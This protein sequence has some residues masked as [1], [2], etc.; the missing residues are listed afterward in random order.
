[1]VVGSAFNTKY[2]NKQDTFATGQLIITNGSGLTF[3]DLSTPI[4]CNGWFRVRMNI[5]GLTNFPPIAELNQLENTGT[6]FA[7]NLLLN[8]NALPVSV[9]NQVLIDLDSITTG[10]TG[11][12]GTIN[13]SGQTPSAP[14]SGAGATAKT[15]LIGK[16]FTLITD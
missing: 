3:D 7:I 2:E 4:K 15:N 8:S 11:Y 5:S 6:A 12:S 14:P 13:L 16:G 10:Y 1:M 9:V